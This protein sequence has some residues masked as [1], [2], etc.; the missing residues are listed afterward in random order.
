MLFLMRILQFNQMKR[1]LKDNYYMDSVWQKM[2]RNYKLLIKQKKPLKFLKKL[3]NYALI[4]ITKIFK[5]KYIFIFIEP[6][7]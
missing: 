5:K 2:E 4:L 6:K 3:N 1:I 7:S